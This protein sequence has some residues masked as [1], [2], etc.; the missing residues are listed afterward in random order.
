MPP[1][2]VA[3]E[4]Y[5][6]CPYTRRTARSLVATGMGVTILSD[7]VYRPWSL[8]GQHVEV[9][10]VSDPVPRMDVGLAWLRGGE[11]SGPTSAF[12]DY[13]R[14]SFADTGF[15]DVEGRA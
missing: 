9:R 10:P 12:Y 13:L 4:P 3:K 15:A 7:M 5:V 2:D 8:E 1:A 11:M 14:L 6:C